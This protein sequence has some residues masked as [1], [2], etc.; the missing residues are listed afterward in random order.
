MAPT[1]NTIVEVDR[2]DY[3][4]TRVVEVPTGPLAP[5]SVRFEVERFAITANT[6]TYALVGDMLGYWGFFPAEQGWGRV[7]AIGWARVTESTHSD[8]P[9][10][11]KYFG[12]FPMA[13]T[14]DVAVSPTPDGVRDE[15]AHREPHAAVYRAF[16]NS[17][18]DPFYQS[19]DDAEDRHALLRGLFLTGFLADD[20]LGD[21][22]YFSASQVA[23]LS[24]SSKT[25]IAFAQ[26]AAAREGIDVIGLTSSR[27][28]DFVRGIGC[29]SR[30]V[31][32]D[33]IGDVN[34]KD[35]VAVDM[36]GNAE[37]LARLHDQLADR[38]Q[39][40]MTIGKSH[41]N[42]PQHPPPSKGP[43]PQMFFAPTQIHKRIKEWGH[44]GYQKRTAAALHTFVD[45][46]GQWLD[47]E[48]VSGVEAVQQTWLDTFEGR[49]PP[50]SGRIATLT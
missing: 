22:S 36:A 20:F 21:Q 7:P 26:L 38:L 2:S 47:V 1:N 33:D 17:A 6:T 24:A 32:Y 50:R 46:S 30:V 13:R 48:R 16:V 9:T 15:G 10:G 49:V 40:S 18:K 3:R 39:Y 11:G 12:W 23:V 19:G 41:A 25:A 5:S 27:N 28:A 14:V 44:D 31:T 43:K 8:V 42:A 4:R 35:T 34:D 45:A 29:Y 37:V